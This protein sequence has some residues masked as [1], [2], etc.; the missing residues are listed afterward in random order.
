MRQRPQHLMRAFARAGV[1][2]I[3]Q[4]SVHPP[5]PAEEPLLEIVGSEARLC[6]EG[7]AVYIY[8]PELVRDLDRYAGSVLVYD[9]LDDLSLHAWDEVHAQHRRLLERA[10]IVLTTSWQLR[11]RL[12]AA[13]PDAILVPNGVWPEDFAAARGMERPPGRPPVVGYAGAV[14]HWFDFA[15]MEAVA[16]ALP[17]W[18]FRL[19]GRVSEP[20]RMAALAARCPNV[21]HEGVLDYA[22][23]P[24]FY[25]GVDIGVIP[26]VLN[27]IT[28]PVSPVK[29]FE[30]F[31]AGRPVVAT[32][33]RE[34][35]RDELVLL[36]DGA[37]EFTEQ[38]R[39]ALP[40]RD[41]PAFRERALAAARSASWE[42]RARRVLDALERHMRGGDGGGE[43]DRR[44]LPAGR[45][46]EPVAVA[47]GAIG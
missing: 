21:S 4:N 6:P 32:R 19:V 20:G 8:N 22:R 23:L 24:E 5:T 26:F 9:M 27:D 41:D 29:L 11:D 7:Q 36:A 44:R 12:R 30:Y 13:R 1:L 47:R 39:R 38:L 45:A 18:R 40:L 37:A 10:D 46:A 15:L 17:D 3:F 25:G 34:I 28:H 14:A 16:T 33:M 2:S 43:N 31:A 35:A 42:G